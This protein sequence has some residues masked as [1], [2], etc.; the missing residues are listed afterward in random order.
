MNHSVDIAIEP[1]E[2]AEFGG[3]L[4]FA[5]DGRT[6]RVLFC[7]SLPWVLLRLLEA[8]ADPALVA[9]DFEHGHGHDFATTQRIRR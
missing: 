3:V 8:Q 5:F 7:K 2:Q 6:D 1:D 9:I 4:D